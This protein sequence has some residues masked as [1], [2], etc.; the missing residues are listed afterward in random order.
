MKYAILGNKDP[1]LQA[2]L[3]SRYQWE[4]AV[5][6]PLPTWRYPDEI[7]TCSEHLYSEEQHGELRDKIRELLETGV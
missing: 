5:F 6:K 3:I 1:F 7:W 4:S 2:H